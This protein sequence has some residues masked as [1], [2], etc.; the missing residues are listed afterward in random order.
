MGIRRVFYYQSVFRDANGKLWEQVTLNYHKADAALRADK[1]A[2]ERGVTRVKITRLAA[3][4]G[5]ARIQL[6]PEFRQI[7]EV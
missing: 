7:K 4:V 3:E 5:S 1:I 2:E 6:L